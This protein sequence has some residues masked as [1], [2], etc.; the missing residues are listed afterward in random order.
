MWRPRDLSDPAPCGNLRWRMCAEDGGDSRQL[1]VIGIDTREGGIVKRLE[2]LVAVFVLVS[3]LAV[4]S[5]M[6][7]GTGDWRD[8]ERVVDGDTLILDGG[9][10]VRLIGVDT[11]ETVRS[12]AG[13]RD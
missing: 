12:S 1:D 11:P 3:A 4:A 8:V 9:E 13:D 6:P 7:D 5:E 10:R 2:V